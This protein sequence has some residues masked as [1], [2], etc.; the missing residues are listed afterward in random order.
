LDYKDYYAALGVDRQATGTEIQKAYR[1]LARKLHPDV[2]KTAEAEG[3][4]KEITEAYEVLKNDEKRAKYDQFGSAWKQAQSSG[5]GPPPGFEDLFDSFGGQGGRPRGGFQGG[6]S[7]F[8][9]FFE[10][11]F[12]GGGGGGGQSAAWNWQ[13]LSSPTGPAPD[14][15]AAIALTLE[16]AAKGGE[17]EITLGDPATGRNRTLRVKIPAGVRSGQRIR[18]GGQGGKSAAGGKA[19]D[20]YLKVNLEP[21]RRFRLDGHHL[22]TT[23]EVTPSEAALGGEAEVPTLNGKI[24]VRIPPGSSSGRKIRLR[25]KGYPSGRGAGDLIAKIR[26]VVPSELSAA[27]RALYEQ[28]SEVS[29]FRPRDDNL[30]Q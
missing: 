14:H 6:G 15:E 3:R 30:T 17:R 1:K 19:G 18:L 25:G 16:E 20:L 2:N 29:P 4:F 28:L 8:S 13:D 23:L 11:L 9:S 10:A 27:E 12:G 26:V 7:G 24:R 22:V 5:G 21:H